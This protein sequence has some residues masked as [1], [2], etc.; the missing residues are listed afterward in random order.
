MYKHAGL[1]G[2]T[3]GGG[4]VC[5]YLGSVGDSR[6]VRGCWYL[7]NRNLDLSL[8]RAHGCGKLVVTQTGNW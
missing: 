4:V 3:G 5:W 2:D 7:L 8:K 1:V 6:R